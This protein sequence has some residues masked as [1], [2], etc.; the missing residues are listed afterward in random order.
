[1]SLGPVI[2]NAL[3]TTKGELK[4]H[5][6]QRLFA[7]TVARQTEE[8]CLCVVEGKMAFVPNYAGENPC[9]PKALKKDA[10]YVPFQGEHAYLNPD[11]KERVL[12]AVHQLVNPHTL[13]AGRYA[14]GQRV[15][16]TKGLYKGEGVIDNFRDGG[17]EMHIKWDT[18]TYDDGWWSTSPGNAEKWE[19]LG[20]AKEEPKAQAAA[21]SMFGFTIG[22]AV[23]KVGGTCN[24]GQVGKVTMFDVAGE[25]VSTNERVQVSFSNGDVFF[26]RPDYLQPAAP[27]IDPMTEPLKVG[28]RVL[29]VRNA[30]SIAFLNGKQGVI[31]ELYDE[32]REGYRIQWDDTCCPDNGKWLR[33]SR[34]KIIERDGQPID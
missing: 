18:P 13:V 10:P 22:Q 3:E 9:P 24:L 32:G 4:P 25:Y 31:A 34:V 26:T 11:P 23:M 1:M 7:D 20:H 27:K 28:D 5:L 8:G 33:R 19:I 30:T 21:Q 16:K 6:A 12:D 15:R 14:L 29:W 17:A 2:R